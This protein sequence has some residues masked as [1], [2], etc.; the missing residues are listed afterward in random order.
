MAPILSRLVLSTLSPGTNVRSSTQN[1]DHVGCIMTGQCSHRH[2]IFDPVNS[3]LGRIVVAGGI[4]RC[5]C[6]SNGS[7]YTYTLLA[8]TCRNL[9]HHR[10]APDGEQ[11][12][13]RHAVR[14]RRLAQPAMGI[15]PHYYHDHICLGQSF[16]HIAGN[17]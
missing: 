4:N 8:T 7:I 17:H 1:L 10:Y 9:K 12:S 11:Q 6:F 16:F 14:C 5:L 13:D 15:R 2:I 3:N